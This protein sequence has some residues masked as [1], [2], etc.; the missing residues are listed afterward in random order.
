MIRIAFADWWNDFDIDNNFITEALK[1]SIDYDTLN[2]EQSVEDADFVFCSL[3]GNDYL[4][5]KCPR[6][7]F[8]GENCVPD[9]N[10]YDYGIGFEK[11]SLG[12][13]YIRYPLYAAYYREACTAMENYNDKTGTDDEFLLKRDFCS[14]VVSNSRY[15]DSYRNELFDVLSHYRF[16]ASGGRYNNNIGMPEGVKDK[17]EFISK[18]KFNIACENISHPGYCTEKIVE[19]FAAGTVPIYWG[20][21]DVEEYFNP[22]AFI[23]C[24][25][26]DSLDEAV[27][28][29]KKIDADDGLY[30]DMLCQPKIIDPK[31]SIANLHAE[32]EK[33]LLIIVKQD[34]ES[35][36]RRSIGGWAKDN[37]RKVIDLNETCSEYN[38][39]KNRKLVR[40]SNYLQF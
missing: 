4:K 13:R 10:L 39:I 35:A 8:C 37:E 1:N 30:L 25:R 14:I 27:E 36:F 31:Y 29:I 23:N 20:D 32:F 16:V 18:Y 26:F 28:Y 6:I 2:K 7:L 34:N 12:D 9:F 33:W 11:L 22:K 21:P 5:Y 17:K 40:L 19:A 24:N 38:K 3:F 15:S